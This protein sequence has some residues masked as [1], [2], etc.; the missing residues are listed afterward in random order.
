[1]TTCGKE[2]VGERGFATP[3]LVVAGAVGEGG[4][5]RVLGQ[6]G[7]KAKRVRGLREFRREALRQSPAVVVCD[8]HLPDGTW[9][10]VLDLSL[11]L[12]NP[13]PVVV[14]SRVADEHLWAEVLN[15]GGYDLLAMP[16]DTGE[17]YRAIQLAWQHW[18][19]QQRAEPEP[20][21]QAR[22]ASA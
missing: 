14:T 16:L 20:P 8:E 6:L 13:P 3:A 5:G 22:A 19:N 9:R 4:D 7:W 17:V 11:S 10:D 1:M 18:R 15:L 21:R 2:P 12:R